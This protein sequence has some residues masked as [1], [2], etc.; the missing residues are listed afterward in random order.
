MIY[1][2]LITLSHPETSRDLPLYEV[3]HTYHKQLPQPVTASSCS[4][5]QPYQYQLSVSLLHKSATLNRKK[6]H[7]IILNAV[8]ALYNPFMALQWKAIS[9]YR[10]LRFPMPTCGKPLISSLSPS[11][12]PNSF[13]SQALN[14]CLASGPPSHNIFVTPRY[15]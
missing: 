15:P 3:I 12:V 5:V 14:R 4:D 6:V 10:K 11:Q 8:G 7:R 2:A 13:L 1:I 9:V